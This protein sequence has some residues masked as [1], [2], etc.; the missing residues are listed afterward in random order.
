MR[1][2]L[3]I[4]SCSIL[5]LFLLLIGSFSHSAN[6]LS[7]KYRLFKTAIKL[8]QPHRKSISSSSSSTSQAAN[9]AETT[10]QIIKH[11]SGS[12]VLQTAEK[13]IRKRMPYYPI[14]DLALQVSG[15]GQE[16]PTVYVI[17]KRFNRLKST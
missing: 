16:S 1:H 5:I 2:K 17:K 10:S 9:I 3:L 13:Y 6:C 14:L 7:V 12:N 8:T 15:Y 11:A 4:T